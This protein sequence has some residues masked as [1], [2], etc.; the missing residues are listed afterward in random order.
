MFHTMLAKIIL[1]CA[2]ALVV[3]G[4]FWAH[5]TLGG[6]EKRAAFFCAEEP[7]DY[8]RIRCLKPYLEELTR[9]RGASHATRFLFSLRSDDVIADCH[10][11]LHFIGEAHV[12]ASA[13]LGEALATCPTG[14]FEGCQHGV[15]EG[16]IAT[17]GL[18]DVTSVCADVFG[19]TLHR[20]CVHGLGHG[21]LR[22]NTRAVQEALASCTALGGVDAKTC[23][24]GVMM[25]YIDAQIYADYE[26][27]LDTFTTTC[28]R[29]RTDTSLYTECM[30]N[31]GWGL[32]VATGHNIER[33]LKLCERFQNNDDITACKTYA[34]GEFE[35]NNSVPS[36]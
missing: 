18:L 9:E 10:V 30:D 19:D 27:F 20:Q 15:V 28:E 1:A 8:A 32:M 14:C 11:P 17:H 26:T 3:L 25:E 21:L 13:S 35:Q 22:H 5:E 33:G 4:G 23:T 24:G 36:F 16:H 6:T 34:L 2:V 31:V 12:R 7:S 29:F